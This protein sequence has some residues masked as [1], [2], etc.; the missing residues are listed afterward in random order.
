MKEAHEEMVGGRQKRL[1]LNLNLQISNAIV[2][3][4]ALLTN[5]NKQIHPHAQVKSNDGVL[6]AIVLW[7]IHLRTV[8]Y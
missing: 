1:N 2:A 8:W 7:K 6:N 5:V 3:N 4:P